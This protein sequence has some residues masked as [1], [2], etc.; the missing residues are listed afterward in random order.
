MSS[1]VDLWL[2]ISVLVVHQMFSIH[3]PVEP[4]LA[5]CTVV[6]L[7]DNA[8]YSEII[9]P[10]DTGLFL[11]MHLSV[12][13]SLINS[14]HR[15][16]YVRDMIFVVGSYGLKERSIFFCFMNDLGGD[17]TAKHHCIPMPDKT[18]SSI[19]IDSVVDIDRYV[20]CYYFYS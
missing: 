18:R 19:S 6:T 17:K 11:S 3:L 12:H 13:I 15:A 5:L 8:S 14:L 9:L 7:F 10:P 2:P 1:A 4:F 16:Y 20:M